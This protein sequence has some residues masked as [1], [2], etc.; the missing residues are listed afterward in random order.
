MKKFG[1]YVMNKKGLAVLETVVKSFG[2]EIVAFVQSAPNESVKE[3]Y[4]EAIT[5][6]CKNNKIDFFKRNDGKT[7]D[8]YFNFA[9]GWRWLI[10]DFKKLVVFH[11]SLLPKYR[12]FNPL[13]SCLINKE[14]QVGVTALYA[15]PEF[16]VGDILA[17]RAIQIDHPIRVE[18]AT[19]MLIPLYCELANELIHKMTSEN[20]LEGRPQDLKAVTYSLWRDESDYRINWDWSAEKIQRHV[21]AVGFPYKGASALINNRLIRIDDVEVLPSVT[22]ENP[23]PGKVLFVTQGIPTIVCGTGLLKIKEM[24]YDEGDESALPLKTYRSRFE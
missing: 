8:S 20:V 17:Q 6:F 7:P 12:G 21:Y 2:S 16:D 1:F 22:I 5:N 19:E 11:D 24:R 9:V 18:K 15:G 10:T 3:D 13:V 23:S 4:Y 14:P